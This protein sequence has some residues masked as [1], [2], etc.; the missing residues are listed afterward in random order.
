MI[1][2]DQTNF[3]YLSNLLP[4]KRKFFQAFTK[5]LHVSN[6]A[7]SILPN[8]KDIWCVDYMP[9]QI[10]RNKF[11]QF[12]YEPDYLQTPKWIQTQTDPA[13]VC[14]EISISPIKSGIKLDGGNVIKANNWVIVTDKLFAENR[15]IEPKILINRLEELLEVRVIVIPQEPDEFTGHADGIVRYYNDDTVLVN[16]YN[17]THL[18]EFQKQLIKALTSSGLRTIPIPYNPYKNGNQISAT[19]LYINFLKMENVVVIPTFKLHEDELA[20]RL[21]EE[22]FST[23]TIQ[24]IDSCE[25]SKDGGVLNCITWNISTGDKTRANTGFV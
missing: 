11:I 4:A 25:I 8:T 9:V 2:D 3:L 19:G 12:L 14:E 20:V 15:T 5:L 6:I 1:T 21:F 13:K 16:N 18:S 7:H 23:Q 17:S 22:L 24:T 10:G